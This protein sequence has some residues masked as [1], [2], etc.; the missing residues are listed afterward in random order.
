MIWLAA[1]EDYARFFGGEDVRPYRVAGNVLDLSEMDIDVDVDAMVDSGVP[2]DTAEIRTS[3]GELYEWAERA[4]WELQD[5]GYDGVI[6]YQQHYQYGPESQRTILVFD[7]RS[8]E[9]ID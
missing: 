5:L 8:L 9:R 1:D 6:V 7:P 3:S 2:R 4:A